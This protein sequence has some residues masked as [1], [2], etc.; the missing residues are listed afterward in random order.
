M[1]S[2]FNTLTADQQAAVRRV[3]G[4]VQ[5]SSEG[6]QKS[7]HLPNGDEAY[8]YPGH[9]GTNWGLNSKAMGGFCA[10]R[11]IWPKGQTA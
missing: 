8:A 7:E 6:G 11:G 1:N 4:Q 5:S 2:E 3:V 10:A 9:R